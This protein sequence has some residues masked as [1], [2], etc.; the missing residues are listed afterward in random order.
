[1][2]RVP[3]RAPSLHPRRVR[4]PRTGARIAAAAL[5]AFA[6]AAASATSAVAPAH[7]QRPTATPSAR[8]YLPAL[9]RSQAG[10]PPTRAITTL[11]VPAEYATIAAALD[12]ARSG[13]TVQVAAGT[14]HEQYLQVPEGV[15]LVGAGWRSTVLDVADPEGLAS[16][17]TITLWRR[18][19]LAGF[20]VVGNVGDDGVPLVVVGINATQGSTITDCR[21]RHASTGILV[22]AERT[23]ERASVLRTIIAGTNTAVSAI[24]PA[25]VAH[26]TIVDNGN[27]VVVGADSASVVTDNLIAGNSRAGMS[28]YD[29][30][31]AD[32]P[33][34]W[35]GTAHHNLVTDN[36]VDYGQGI[37]PGAG[38]VRS[39]PYLVDPTVGEMGL[40]AGSPARGAASDGGDIGALPFTA[41]GEPPAGLRVDPQPE[42]TIA[43]GRPAW[44]ASWTALPD[45]TMYYVWV[46]DEPAGAAWRWRII[47]PPAFNWSDL[48]ELTFGTTYRVSVSAVTGAGATDLAPP[49]TFVATPPTV[50]LEDDAAALAR[51]GVWRTVAAAE[52]SG[53]H[54]IVATDDGASLSFA[55]G[56]DSVGVR[57]IIG[58]SGGR[59]RVSV[60]GIDQGP[61]EFYFAEGRWDVPAVYDGFGDGPHT[62]RLV[63]DKD[64]SAASK[65]HEVAVDRAMAPSG[66]VPDGIQREALARVNFLR[67]S[68]G[69]PA[70]RV[71]GALDL[72]T[73]H[74]AAYDQDNGRNEAHNETPGVPGFTGA[75]PWDRAPYFGYTSSVG[76]DMTF[77]WGT[78]YSAA[79]FGY[80]VWAT[81]SWQTTVYHRNLIMGYGHLD[82]GFG[83]AFK[84]DRS[85]GVL[86]MGS[87][88]AGRLPAARTIYTWPIDGAAD[89]PE[90]WSGS[91]GP[92]PL[93]QRD[94][95]VG[96]PVSLYIAQPAQPDVTRLAA[97]SLPSL[98]SLFL[99]APLTAHQ[100]T[101]WKVATGELRDARGALVKSYVLEQKND[102]PR[103]LGPDNVFLIAEQPMAMGAR[104]DVR[105]AGTDSRGVAFDTRW[106]F[107]TR[108]ASGI[109]NVTGDVGP[110]GG[111]IR[112]STAG[113][114]VGRVRY[115]DAAGAYPSVV[116]ETGPGTQHTVPIAGAFAP[117]ATVHYVVETTDAGGHTSVT[118]DRTFTVHDAR[119]IAVPGDA[120]TIG[121]ALAGARACDHVVV[122]PATYAEVV[123]VPSGVTLS[124]AGAATTVIRGPGK[125]NVVTLDDG[126]V[127][128]GFT[129]T[130]G[131]QGYWDM[132]VFIGEGANATVRRNRLTGN[133][134]GVGAY[135]FGER[136]ANRPVIENNVVDG[137]KV[138]GIGA[139]GVAV[140]ALNNTVWG[141][142]RGIAVDVPGAVIRGNIVGR[143]EWTG[144]GGATGQDVAYNDVWQAGTPYDQAQ[145]GEGA[146]SV[147]PRFVDAAK[148]DYHLAP[149]SPCID[150]GDPAVDRR[151]HDGT[152]GD[153]GAYGGQGAMP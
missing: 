8:A 68:A 86:L 38:D 84:G 55:F 12:A 132:G 27:G 2:P 48:A 135:C 117:G 141:S 43:D 83:Y 69:L 134:V 60:D 94:D 51:E 15:R 109:D 64:A 75:R 39:N 93:P 6:V 127:I 78:T 65:G 80:G 17:I 106:S 113:V 136:C 142:Q 31:S 67:T 62:F 1:M 148:G 153:M 85:T 147:D 23:A 13:D 16:S 122:A 50:A 20:D 110:C 88:A 143:N 152:R 63:V 133:G 34:G 138:Q 58:P 40:T 33:T 151:D 150:A 90:Q 112:W 149:G 66:V 73:M 41:V 79:G 107:T 108:G 123:R 28:L 103:F 74:H 59:A 52:A 11:R 87:R 3:Q 30:P 26:N 19:T 89:V 98:L 125:A 24:G 46:S 95:P 4:G 77:S 35:N 102:A 42:Q 54:Y 105:V 146:L 97:T 82:M 49:V 36:P 140:I 101:P 96:Y 7:A 56:G 120:A 91:E 10:F 57:R 22:D 29:D 137:N 145:S 44:R 21:L 121:A 37:V 115:G 144:I 61:L 5:T 53:G 114:A 130:G 70:V 139:H 100:A 72:A 32:P 14:Y 92:D 47:V 9:L 81:D 104:Y 25:T 131:G 124:G 76:E 128:E 45:A 116:E 111:R 71:A 18:A 99:I 129:V 126:S 119:T 118:E